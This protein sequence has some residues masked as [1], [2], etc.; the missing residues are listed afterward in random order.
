M[1]RLSGHILPTLEPDDIE[2]EPG[3][4]DLVLAKKF[5]KIGSLR[6]G[7]NVSFYIAPY[8]DPIMTAYPKYKAARV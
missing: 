7:S 1:E 3:P 5:D 8:V 4:K 6:E 2:E